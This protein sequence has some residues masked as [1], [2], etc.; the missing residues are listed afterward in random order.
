MAI[1][2]LTI[3][4]LGYSAYTDRRTLTVYPMT[5]VGILLIWLCYRITQLIKSMDGLD[6]GS[7]RIFDYLLLSAISLLISLIFTYFYGLG[8]ADVI[9]IMI[10]ILMEGMEG[11]L[12]ICIS[13]TGFLLCVY[14]SDTDGQ[15]T[16]LIPFFFLA[17][18]SCL[19]VRIIN[20]AVLFLSQ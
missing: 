10:I 2:V 20:E 17:E 1:Y 4:T 5:S 3:L 16:P 15:N 12:M 8:L 18:C 14:A 11:L 6:S 9:W 7:E 13:L 19:A